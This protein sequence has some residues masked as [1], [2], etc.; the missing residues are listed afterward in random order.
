MKPTSLAH[1]VRAYRFYAPFYDHLYGYVLD[2]GRLA[3][4]Q[5]VTALCP[6]SVLE[7]GVGTGLT[8]AGYPVELTI[9]GIDVSEEML[10]LARDRGRKLDGHNIRLEIMDA[11]AMSFPDASFDCV[12][13]P[14]VLSV[15]PDPEKLIAE[16]RRVCR[17]GGT[18]LIL[19]HF[20]G[21]RFW[22][23]LERAARPIADRI[24]FRSDFDF[25]DHI[26]KYDWKIRSVKSVNLFGLSKLVEIHNT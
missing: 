24:G 15:T 21:S 14:Y 22:W 12:T 16:A 7:I 2:R 11:E 20:T 13:M 10:K 17:K 9:V 5:A 26:L 8:L 1:V 4:S 25:S 18:I 3:L 23:L 19:N 6:A